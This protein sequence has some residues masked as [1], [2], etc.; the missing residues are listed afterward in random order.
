LFSLWKGKINPDLYGGEAMIKGVLMLSVFAS[1][2]AMAS[3]GL[4]AQEQPAEGQAS[5]NFT[6]FK[7]PT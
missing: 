5:R 3:T 4:L 7:S 2:L 1:L 6:V